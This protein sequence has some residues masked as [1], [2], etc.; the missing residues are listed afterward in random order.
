[1]PSDDEFSPE[2]ENNQVRNLKYEVN[3]DEN[4]QYVITSDFSELIKSDEY[5][6][7]KM[8]GVEATFLENGKIPI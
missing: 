3:F 8:Q 6:I 4:N 1:M 5:E 2:S 7:V